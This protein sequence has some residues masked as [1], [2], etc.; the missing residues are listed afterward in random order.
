MTMDLAPMAILSS[1]ETFPMKKRGRK[2][3]SS[4]V[5][6]QMTLAE[7]NQRSMFLRNMAILKMTFLQMLWLAQNWTP[8]RLEG[9]TL[10][11]PLSLT[12]TCYEVCK[13]RMLTDNAPKMGSSFRLSF[14]FTDASRSWWINKVMM[15][16]RTNGY[17]SMI[18]IEWRMTWVSSRTFWTRRLT[19]CWRPIRKRRM[20]RFWGDLTS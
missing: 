12:K 14:V 3:G 17:P 5:W 7:W 8:S 11:A 2:F 4:S 19:L 6:T 18:S 20:C 10:S 16:M 9:I 15:F 1:G 13:S